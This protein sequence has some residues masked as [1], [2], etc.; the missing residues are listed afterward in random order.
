MNLKT[1]ALKE[2]TFAPTVDTGKRAAHGKTATHGARFDCLISGIAYN[3]GVA[4]L[5][6]G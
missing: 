2:S 4:V 5:N 1:T 6:S 3:A